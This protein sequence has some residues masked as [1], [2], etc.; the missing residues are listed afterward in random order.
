MLKQVLT[1][2]AERRDA[3]A[4]QI[5]LD[6]SDAQQATAEATRA[7]TEAAASAREAKVLVRQ[8]RRERARLAEAQRAE[9]GPRERQ[10]FFGSIVTQLV[11]V[12]AHVAMQ[13]WF[14]TTTI[15][16]ETKQPDAAERPQI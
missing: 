13:Q 5:A 1:S 15:N 12:V 10:W 8:L 9:A 2:D 7:A 14:K 6:R 16:K 11:V 3:V 4:V